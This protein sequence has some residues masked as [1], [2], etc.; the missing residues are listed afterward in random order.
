[1]FAKTFK[2]VDQGIAFIEEWTLFL[3]V[4]VALAVA[5]ANVFLRKFTSVNLYWSDEVVRKVIYISTYVGCSAAIRNRSLI[6]V[7]AVPQLFPLLKKPLTYFS[8]LVVLAFS[9][10]VFWLGLQLT[11][12][13]Y[14]DEYALTATLEIPEWILYAILPAT[15]AMSVIRSLLVIIEELRSGRT[16][17]EGE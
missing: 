8:H 7:D 17:K 16:A 5:L 15:G 13:V 2:K 3:A 6:R 10:L 12:I 11:M 1:M 4:M 14:Q 9:C